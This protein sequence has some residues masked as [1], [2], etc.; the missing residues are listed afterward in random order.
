[1]AE[2]VKLLT[3]LFLVFREEGSLHKLQTGLHNAIIKNK[4]DTLKMTVPSFVYVLQNNLL[5]V[6]ASHLDAATYQ[7]SWLPLCFFIR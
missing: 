4:A 6:S 7:V 1:M 2:M 3:C 5:Y